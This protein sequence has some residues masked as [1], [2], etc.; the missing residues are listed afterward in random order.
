MS[1]M[2]QIRNVPDDVHRKI[3]SRA[4]LAGMS[5]SEWLLA[6]IRRSLEKP[7]RSEVLARIARRPSV[8]ARVDTAAAVRAERERR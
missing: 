1:V 8:G 2:V 6:E 4:A 3:K 5:V 7:D